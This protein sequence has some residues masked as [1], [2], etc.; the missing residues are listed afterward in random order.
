MA[1]CVSYAI[2]I[3]DNSSTDLLHT[4]SSFPS[5]GYETAAR[6]LFRGNRPLNP[7]PRYRSLDKDQVNR[8]A[9]I[10]ISADVGDVYVGGLVTCEFKTGKPLDLFLFK[11]LID[12][13]ILVLTCEQELRALLCSYR[14]KTLELKDRSTKGYDLMSVLIDLH[15]LKEK[16]GC[17]ILPHDFSSLLKN[18]NGFNK[19]TLYRVGQYA[20][21]LIQELDPMLDE[22]ITPEVPE[23]Q[24]LYQ[25]L[26]KG[27]LFGPERT[28][29]K[30]RQ[31][32]EVDIS[33]EVKYPSIKKT[34]KFNERKLLESKAKLA[35]SIYQDIR[36]KLKNM[37]E[38][39]RRRQIGK[40]RSL[41]PPMRAIKA[42]Y[43]AQ[44]DSKQ[45]ADMIVT[46]KTY[47][48][49]PQVGLT[50]RQVEVLIDIV[51]GNE[52]KHK[53]FIENGFI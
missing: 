26:M 4:I 14:T 38:R 29:L 23:G 49:L 42:H 12:H 48:T 44:G 25:A 53:T 21:T 2:K 37:S 7:S 47:P 15:S 13:K 46:H 8:L 33:T 51:Q 31:S 18:L 41:R 52:E 40:I 30:K 10:D 36:V 16:I 11:D 28:P 3:Q 24:D 45:A 39:D 17:L 5:L 34:R 6:I 22:Y 50:K 32:E 20:I 43:R 1:P 35:S 19:T 9:D 27:N